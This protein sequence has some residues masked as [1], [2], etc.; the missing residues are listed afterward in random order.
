MASRF[1]R[2]TSTLYQR[3]RGSALEF[4]VIAV[5]GMG[6]SLLCLHVSHYVLGVTTLLADNISANVIGLVLGAASRF[7]LYR[8]WAF[9]PRRYDGLAARTARAE[10]AAS[11]QSVTL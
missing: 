4:G 5:V 8:F 10:S 7:L 6:I 2:A 1:A 3:L 9:S 11:S